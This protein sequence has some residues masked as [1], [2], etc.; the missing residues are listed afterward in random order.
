MAINGTKSL[1]ARIEKLE[2]V[3]APVSETDKL[4]VVL[5]SYCEHDS[6]VTGLLR[7][8]DNL[9]ID[10]LPGET[11]DE[12]YARAKAEMPWKLGTFSQIRGGIARGGKIVQP[13]RVSTAGSEAL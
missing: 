7:K 12:L 6:E 8:E 11:E 5:T 10:R 13:D 1:L 9:V 3:Y 4:M 2:Q